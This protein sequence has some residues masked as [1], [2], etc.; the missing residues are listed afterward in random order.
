MC[1]WKLEVN[2]CL[3]LLVWVSVVIVMVGS[4]WVFMLMFL[5]R[6]CIRL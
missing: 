3:W 2:V 5:C 1:F 4:I 6:V